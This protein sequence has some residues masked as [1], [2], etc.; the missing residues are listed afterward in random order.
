MPETMWAIRKLRARAGPRPR[1]GAG[2]A[3]GDDD[4]LVRVEAASLCGTDLHIFHW[5]DWA[6]HRVEPAADAR[7][8][9]RRDGR[10]GRPQRAP[11]RAPATTSPPRA[12]S[13]AAC[14]S[15]AG[16]ARRT[17]ASRPQILG[18]DR[19]GAFA[20][21]V[22]VPESVIWLNDRSK[23]PPEIATLQEPFGN[24]VFA[25][26]THDLAG[27]DGRDPR[28]RPGRAVQH[29]DRARLRS[30]ARARLGSGPVPA[31]ARAHDGRHGRRRRSTTSRTS[32]P[33]SSSETR[34]THLDVVFEMSGAP[35]AI[36]DSF[37]IVRNGGHVVL[38][39]I[40]SRPVE[41]DIAESLIFKNLSV[42]ALSGRQVFGTWY[43]TRWLLEHGVV[44]LR[45]L[46]T[47]RCP[48]T[49]FEQALAE[50]DAG[51]A[52]KVVLCPSEASR[53]RSEAARRASA[54]RARAGARWRTMN[55][56]LREQ[57]AAELDALRAANTY[58]TL[59]DASLSAG[60]GGR[61][62][63]PR[64]GDRPLLEQ[65]PRPRRP[66]EAVI[67]AGAG[68]ARPLRRRHGVGSLHLRHVR[69]RTSSSR[70]E[71]ADLVGTEAA[72]TYA[73]CWNAN[74]AVIPSLTDE[75]TVL[76]SD[77]L[78]HASIVDAMR[79]AKPARK[80]VFPHSDMG[81][82]RDAL[83]A[84]EPG[85]RKLVVTDGVFSM[86]GDVARLPEIVE[87]ARDARR[88]RDR[89]RL[90]RRRAS[91]ARPGGASPSTSACSAR[92]T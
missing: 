47:H 53:P 42:T 81:A 70:R 45:P 23:L 59:P 14:A 19:D 15:T 32:R 41:V 51:R 8:R 36:G 21:Y 24:A 5:D 3:L 72:L 85:Q 12:T 92:S 37:R 7:P 83:R 84:C 17:C 63:G 40:P 20:E 57:V 1:R 46:I 58:K 67:E 13:P 26:S 22:A 55:E 9:V 80:V 66:S 31:R 87:L 89:R 38:F 18:V 69:S 27:Q 79:L 62:G 28:L 6:A 35:D 50:L 77:E 54:A 39:G 25:T 88:D 49:G 73:S 33:G 30:R 56:R 10:R 60:P 74:E 68:R 91:W 78:N 82:L 65:L 4:V 90:A 11:H 48:L 64:R 76:I 52:C 16:R 29:R 34:A 44:D 2:A 71:L 61:D 86:E 43:T 75:H